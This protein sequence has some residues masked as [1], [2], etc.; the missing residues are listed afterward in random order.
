MDFINLNIH[1]LKVPLKHP[2]HLSFNTIEHFDTCLI[3]FTVDNNIYYGECTALPGYSWETIDSIWDKLTNWI[4]SSDKSL[5]KLITITRKDAA[6]NPFAAAPL[7]T[8]FEKMHIKI[9]PISFSIPIVGTISSDNLEM[10]KKQTSDLLNAGYK[11]IKIKAKGEASSDLKKITFIQ[12]ISNQKV[13]LRIDANQAYDFKE[14]K[15]FMEKIDPSDIELFEQPFKPDQWQDMASLAKI[16]PIP[17]MLDESIWN[18]NDILKTAKSDCAHYVK[19]KLFKHVT[20][21][22]TMELIKLA[23]ELGLKVIFGNGVQTDI[24]CYDESLIYANANLETDAEMNGFLKQNLSLFKN[25]ISFKNGQIYFSEIPSIDRNVI[26]EYTI[27][28]KH[29][30]LKNISYNNLG[31]DTGQPF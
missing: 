21:K 26:K 20:P 9:P 13:K 11:T 18:K 1:H 16:S 3:Y 10:I 17:L 6:K 7:L 2:Y 27:R 12:K 23:H 25:P 24:G 30:K 4:I 29:Y 28:N 31:S 22:H 19:L 15:K 8:A 14:I 5:T